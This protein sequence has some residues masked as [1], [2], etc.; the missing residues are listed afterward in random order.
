MSKYKFAP[1][2]RDDIK[3]IIDYT[4]K[5]W[6]KAQANKYI[7]ELEALAGNLAKTPNLGKGRDALHKGLLSYLYQS[8]VLYYLKRKN[9]II[10]IRILHARMHPEKHLK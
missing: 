10:I 2:A 4:L 6:G 3:N 5:K 7:D 9:G 1:E 8:H